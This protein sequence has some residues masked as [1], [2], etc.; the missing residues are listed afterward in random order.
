[1]AA[2]VSLSLAAAF[3]PTASAAIPVPN[4]G[5]SIG[6]GWETR[7]VARA[8]SKVVGHSAPGMSVA[9]VK[10]NPNKLDEA[11]TTTY[12]FGMADKESQRRVGPQTQFEIASETKTFTAAL[13]AKRIDEDLSTLD[14]LAQEYEQDVTFPTRN[15]RTITLGDLVTHRSGLT[16]DPGNLNA[17]CPGGDSCTDAKALYNRNLL[18]EGLEAPG[19]LADAPGSTWTYSDFGFGTLG[20]LMADA[21]EPGH[22]EPRFADVV[23]RELTGPLGMT[24]TIIESPTPDLAVPY[25]N[26]SPTDLWNNTGALAGGGGLIS[27]ASDMAKWV[28]ATLGYGDNPL[29]PVL[30]SMLTAIPGVAPT[31]MPRMEMGMAWQLFPAQNGVAEPY[32]FKNGGASGTTSATY[33]VPS[34]GWGV[35]VMANGDDS[36]AT[37]GAAFD[38]MRELVPLLPTKPEGNALGSLSFGS[39][40][41]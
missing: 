40:G 14:D 29:V 25:S 5:S 7:A 30:Q 16:D 8:A 28:A 23:Q 6:N 35:T 37:D 33:L 34:Q 13:L 18:W 2:A 22:A 3:A 27:T 21:Y 32:A 26:G 10:R 12:Y 31:T 1:M 36:A 15:G 17:G 20:T 19:A 11:I 9:I 4:T 39:L 41:S 38:L 24:G